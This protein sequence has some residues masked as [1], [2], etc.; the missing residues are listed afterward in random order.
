MGEMGLLGEFA[1]W[2][3]F[4]VGV[5]LTISVAVLIARRAKK[6]KKGGEMNS[7]DELLT[8]RV[9]ETIKRVESDIPEPLRPYIAY[10]G[11]APEPLKPNWF[12]RELVI[13]APGQAPRRVEV[14]QDSYGLLYVRID[15][16]K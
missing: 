4:S 5:A 13:E 7:H 2:A 11:E 15:E 16:A 10:R 14:Y 6:S 9:A 3:G 8:R 12:P 1:F